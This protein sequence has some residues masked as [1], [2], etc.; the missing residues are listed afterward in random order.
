MSV[1]VIA[2]PSSYTPWSELISE[3]APLV[4]ECP[5][6][7]I[8]KSLREVCR[9]FFSTSR[10][11]RERGVTLLSTVASQATYAYANL[12]NSVLLDVMAVWDSDRELHVGLPG[13][14]D[15]FYPGQ[16]DSEYLI[17]VADGGLSLKLS[18]LPRSTGTVL[19]GS[20]SYTLASNA[21]GIPSWVYDE[22]KY[23]IACGAAA[24][25]VMQPKKPW[26]D[27]QSYAMRRREF[28]KCISYA[29]NKAGP[30]RRRPMFTIPV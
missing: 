10:C 6:T 28:E 14:E 16:G 22:H 19:K 13:E 4:P 1:V 26:T 29:S 12:A 7:I 20:V 21:S 5:R 17:T 2:N 9:E 8:E 23:G 25:L 18:P 15:D 3:V 11:W 30:I 27:S 24:P